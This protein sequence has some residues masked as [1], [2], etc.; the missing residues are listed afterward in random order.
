M[1]HVYCDLLLYNDHRQESFRHS[2]LIGKS[3]YISAERKQ[4][5]VWNY[6]KIKTYYHL[7]SNYAEVMDKLYHTRAQYN[8]DWVVVQS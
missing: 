8:E 7:I 5:F 4:L 1:L 6:E 2:L 3:K